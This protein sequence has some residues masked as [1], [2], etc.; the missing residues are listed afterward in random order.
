MRPQL[1]DEQ[2][3]IECRFVIRHLDANPGHRFHDREFGGFIQ[4]DM[5][6]DLY[7]RELRAVGVAVGDEQGLQGAVVSRQLL[8]V[9]RGEDHFHPSPTQFSFRSSACSLDILLR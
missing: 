9:S 5:L 8:V 7:Q 1:P 4:R 3:R 6:A 2:L